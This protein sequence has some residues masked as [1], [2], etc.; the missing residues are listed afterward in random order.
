MRTKHN[1][2]ETPPINNQKPTRTLI[3]Y[4]KT[5]IYPNP[6]TGQ[7]TYSTREH[8]YTKKKSLYH[9]LLLQNYK[10]YLHTKLTRSQNL[11]PKPQNIAKAKTDT[12]KPNKPSNPGQVIKNQSPNVISFKYFMQHR[13]SKH[14]SE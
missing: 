4:Y 12:E 10:L 9:L 8:P 7:R 1:T 14:Q 5:T 3:S 11:F 13:R 6:K 2:Q